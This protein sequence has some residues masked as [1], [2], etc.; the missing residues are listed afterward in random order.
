VRA[1]LHP[2]AGTCRPRY[3]VDC[4]HVLCGRSWD[5]P[6]AVSRSHRHQV[7]LN[8][9]PGGVPLPSDG[10]HPRSDPN[11]R[12]PPASSSLPIASTWF[13]GSL[14]AGA[15]RPTSWP[16]S[17]L[18]VKSQERPV[19]TPSRT[20]VR[21]SLA[22]FLSPISKPARAHPGGRFRSGIAHPI[23]ARGG[24]GGAGSLEVPPRHC[25]TCCGLTT[26][27][28]SCA[29][30]GRRGPRLVRGAGRLI[31][32]P[33]GFEDVVRTIW[34]T[35]R[36]PALAR[37]TV[38]A[39]AEHPRERDRGD[40]PRQR[41]SDGTGT[42]GDLRGAPYVMI[43]RMRDGRRPAPSRGIIRG[44][45]RVDAGDVCRRVRCYNDRWRARAPRNGR[46]GPGPAGGPARGRADGGT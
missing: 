19:A 24:R 39:F 12:P 27:W 32:D 35:N 43:G 2:K 34:T 37:R 9:Q 30:G 4:A 13:C 3:E 44:A 25:N 8:H 18:L 33:T 1:P 36:Q 11:S 22:L 38:T 17:C 46:A 16:S 28:E 26:R 31:R 6:A 29:C 23:G 14:L 20:Y 10:F 40:D 21:L 5:G 7:K 45:R 41:A 15:P 42:S